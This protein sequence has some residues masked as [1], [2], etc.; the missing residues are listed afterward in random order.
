MMNSDKIFG[1][2]ATLKYI[3]SIFCSIFEVKSLGKK[4]QIRDRSK[5]KNALECNVIF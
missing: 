4:F 5:V 2:G 1:L 3:R